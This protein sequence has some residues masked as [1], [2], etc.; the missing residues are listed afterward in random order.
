MYINYKLTF[1]FYYGKLEI[2]KLQI[3][4]CNLAL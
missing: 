2:N 3:F 1:N 4:V